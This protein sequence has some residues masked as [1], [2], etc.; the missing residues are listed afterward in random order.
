MTKV[1]T[2]AVTTVT[3]EEKGGKTLLVLHEL[4]PSK[5]ALDDAVAGMDGWDARD[6]S[7]SWTS[8]SSPWARAWDGHEVDRE[9]RRLPDASDHAPMIS[10]RKEPRDDHH[11]YRL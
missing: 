6:S 4:Y 3:F 9:V 10:A 7:S 2:V 11:D 5:E 8:F 1:M